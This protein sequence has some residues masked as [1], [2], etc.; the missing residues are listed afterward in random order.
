MSIKETLDLLH[1]LYSAIISSILKEFA[2]EYVADNKA[3]YK[4]E[5]ILQLLL[6]H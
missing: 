6:R 1:D 4:I 3:M 5:N 2:T